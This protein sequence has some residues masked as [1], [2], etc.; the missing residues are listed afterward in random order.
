MNNWVFEKSNHDIVLYLKKLDIRTVWQ[1]VWLCLIWSKKKSRHHLRLK[2]RKCSKMFFLKKEVFKCWIFISVK[3][4]KYLKPLI[5][6][7]CSS[8]QV[9]NGFNIKKI[10]LN[11]PTTSTHTCSHVHTRG[12]SHRNECGEWY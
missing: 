2:F 4:L 10:I 12:L 1:C 11:S 3:H 9:F 8:V 5:I 6:L 7:Q